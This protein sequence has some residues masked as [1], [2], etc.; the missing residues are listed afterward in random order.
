MKIYVGEKIY[1]GSKELIVV[2]LTKQDRE[3][4]KNMC[5]GC[6]LYCKYPDKYGTNKVIELL[7]DLKSVLRGK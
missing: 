4:I 7:A 5:K 2:H 6:T 1:D 3:N